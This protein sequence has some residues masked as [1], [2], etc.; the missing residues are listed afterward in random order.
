EPAGTAIWTSTDCEPAPSTYWAHR[1][2]ALTTSVPPAYSTRV[3]SAALTSDRLLG[4]LG[5]T[6]TTVSRR[7]S[8]AIRTSPA[9]SSTLRDIGSGGLK[10][11]MS[12]TP[13]VG[14]A[15]P[16]GGAR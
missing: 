5:R 13:H 10:P 1:R 6:S 3:C 2:G 15:G 16:P 9:P 8:A 14:A 7:S 4:S 12:G 11:A